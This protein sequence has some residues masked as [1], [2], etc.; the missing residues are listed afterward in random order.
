MSK[1]PKFTREQLELLE[2]VEALRAPITGPTLKALQSWDRDRLAGGESIDE[3]RV[4]A[5]AC[6]RAARVGWLTVARDAGWEPSHWPSPFC[7]APDV[8]AHLGSTARVSVHL[9]LE[10]G[11]DGSVS[12][13]AERCDRLN[14]LREPR[15]AGRGLLDPETLGRDAICEGCG[16]PVFGAPPADPGTLSPAEREA[17]AR[18]DAAFA[19]EHDGCGPR[20]SEGG[21]VHCI[22]CC[23]MVGLSRAKV[24]E[25]SSVMTR[26]HRAA[27]E[28]A[29]R[30][31]RID[32]TPRTDE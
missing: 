29:A 13:R 25:L 2:R 1:R 28:R 16:R 5:G 8:I 24:A 14:P 30:R 20:W 6:L 31:R 11:G 7:D 15:W 18:D 27:Q 12:V 32:P 9:L 22:R 23:P 17:R 19:Q 26:H 3:A 4:L 10:H 21:Q